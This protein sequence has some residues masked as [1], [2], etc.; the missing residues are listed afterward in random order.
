MELR[1]AR[2]GVLEET[3]EE[4]RLSM[5]RLT[6]VT[7]EHITARLIRKDTETFENTCSIIV[8][9]NYYPMVREIDHGTWRRL[10][11]LVYPLRFVKP[12]AELKGAADSASDQRCC[13]LRSRPVTRPAAVNSRPQVESRAEVADRGKIGQ[14]L[15]DALIEAILH[16]P[17]FKA[18]RKAVRDITDDE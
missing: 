9:T 13:A 1:G 18:L 2:I 8:S 6:L 7:G 5:T 16:D 17:G 11:A 4:H 14:K 3:P 15:A 12:H 10:L